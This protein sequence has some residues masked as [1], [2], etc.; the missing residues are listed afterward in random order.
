MYQWWFLSCDKCAPV[1]KDVSKWENWVRDTQGI[2]V[3]SFQLSCK[4]QPI[5]K[6]KVYFLKGGKE[7]PIYKVQNICE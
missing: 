1:M 2:F 7:T 3:L 6:L 4:S 5:L